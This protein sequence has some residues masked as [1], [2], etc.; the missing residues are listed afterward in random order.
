[1]IGDLKRALKR[2]LLQR[3]GIPYSPA[4]DLSPAVY[5]HFEGRK[6]L[7]VLDIG[8]HTGQF[9]M[10][11]KKHLTMARALLVEPLPDLAEKMRNE[12]EL[13]GCAI[14]GC[15]A[16]S[17]AGTITLNVFREAPYVSS[18]LKLDMSVPGMREIAKSEPNQLEVPVRTIDGLIESRIGF[19]TIHLLKIDV[20]GLEK[21]VLDG[22][23]RT[24]NRIEAVF[25]EVSFRPVYDGSCTFHDVYAALRADGF[26]LRDLEPGHKS[27]VGELLQADALFVRRV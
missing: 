8:A 6:G 16:G 2:S 1:M 17:A 10:A 25:C 21:Q 24:L 3:W 12:P 20:Q 19:E 9:T 13:A 18:A 7:V 22:A 15:A 23:Q 4:Y 14:E 5:R 27:D 11:V 26:D